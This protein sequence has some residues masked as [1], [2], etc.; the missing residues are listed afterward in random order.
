MTRMLFLQTERYRLMAAFA[1][2]AGIYG[3]MAG[4]L[5]LYYQETYAYSYYTVATGGPTFGQWAAPRLQWMAIGA[6]AV[7]A[8]W[9]G[10]LYLS[11]R[12]KR[13]CADCQTLTHHGTTEEALCPNC[14][15][16]R[17][18]KARWAEAQARADAEDVLRC[19]R[20]RCDGRMMDKVLEELDNGTIM[21]IDRCPNCA[22]EVLS[23]AERE[24]LLAE[25]ESQGY[26]RGRR[27]GQ[28]A[29]TAQAA[30]TIALAAA[31]NASN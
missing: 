16:E 15:D 20:T 7:L 6:I 31:L 13:P 5:W 22:D 27:D 4:G 12:S 8:L 10:F 14:A 9:V 19:S 2:V 26:T 25:A 17:A 18:D 11:F 29:A 28:S 30:S 24:H 1:T 23:G 3:V 21:V